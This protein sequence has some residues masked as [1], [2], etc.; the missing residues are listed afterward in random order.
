M[1]RSYSLPVQC[2][3]HRISGVYTESMMMMMMMMT[4]PIAPSQYHPTQRTNNG[5]QCHVDSLCFE[6]DPHLLATLIGKIT[7]PARTD[8]YLCWET[9]RTSIVRTTKPRRTIVQADTWKAK[10]LDGASEA[11]AAVRMGWTT[12]VRDVVLLLIRQLGNEGTRFLICIGP[13]SIALALS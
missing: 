4:H 5:G 8:L 9:G 3:K 7:A 12:G 6:L 1:D 13:I 10:A 2:Q 11:G